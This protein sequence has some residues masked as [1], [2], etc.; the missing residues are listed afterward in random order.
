MTRLSSEELRTLLLNTKNVVVAEQTVYVGNLAGSAV[1]VGEVFRGPPGGELHARVLERGAE[2]SAVG[3]PRLRVPRELP[4]HHRVHFL[5]HL[6][7]RDLASRA[8]PPR[9]PATRFVTSLRGYSSVG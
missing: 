9:D 8:R 5:R 4:H 6:R 1:R 7:R 2:R 3:P